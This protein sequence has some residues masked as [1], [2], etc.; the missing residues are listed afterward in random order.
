MIDMVLVPAYALGFY[1][2]AKAAFVDGEPFG[3]YTKSAFNQ[4]LRL[5]L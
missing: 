2:I 1:D 5:D 4:F 3:D